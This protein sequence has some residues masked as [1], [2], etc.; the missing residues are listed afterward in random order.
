MTTDPPSGARPGSLPEDRWT[1]DEQFVPLGQEKVIGVSNLLNI[2]WLRR[3]LEMAAPVARI[4]ISGST[5]STGTGF[6][7]AADLLLT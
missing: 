3:G 1:P 6:L 5:Q 2:A 4:L 7:V